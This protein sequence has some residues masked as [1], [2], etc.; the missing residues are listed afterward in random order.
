MIRMYRLT[1]ADPEADPEGKKGTRI[2]PERKWQ[3][4]PTDQQAKS[5][6]EPAGLV[7]TEA[8]G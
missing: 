8:E 4:R 7:D 6:L 5:R 1:L 3:A 2:K